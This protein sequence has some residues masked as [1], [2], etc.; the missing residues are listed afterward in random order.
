[1]NMEQLDTAKMLLDYGFNKDKKILVHT[2]FKR[3]FPG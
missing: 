2:G 3:E 1:M